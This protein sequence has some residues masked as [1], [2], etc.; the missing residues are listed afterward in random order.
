MS[1]KHGLVGFRSMFPTLPL[2]QESSGV[3][4]GLEPEGCVSDH[5]LPTM[6]GA[7]PKRDVATVGAGQKGRGACRSA[8]YGRQ[9][10]RCLVGPRASGPR[11]VRP[12]ETKGSLL[13]VSLSTRDQV[14][15]RIDR[16]D[17]SQGVIGSVIDTRARL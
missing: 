14:D 2:P 9:G 6:S 12:G 17:C 13:R 15:V 16:T 4:V 10:A 7:E 11:V 1:R 3:V 5:A 8:D